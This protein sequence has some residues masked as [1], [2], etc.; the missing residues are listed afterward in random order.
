MGDLDQSK[1]E[2]LLRQNL[3]ESLNAMC[4][5]NMP[6]NKYWE[7]VGKIMISKQILGRMGSKIRINVIV[8]SESGV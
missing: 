5:G 1:L 7:Y 3:Q 2:D 4:G 6:V 8:E